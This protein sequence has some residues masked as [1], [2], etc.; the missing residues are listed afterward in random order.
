MQIAPRSHHFGQI[1]FNS[2]TSF[3][4]TLSPEDEAKYTAGSR[5]LPMEKGEVVL[6]SNQM[7]HRSDGSSNGERRRGFS[8]WLTSA[9]D[10]GRN[11]EGVDAPAQ[12]YPEYIPAVTPL[13]PARL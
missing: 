11:G 13:R 2:T 9:G 10:D 3:D 8:F 7:L 4:A 5:T 1:K 6:L 12:I